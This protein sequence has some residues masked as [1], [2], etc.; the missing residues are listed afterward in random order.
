MPQTLDELLRAAK[1]TLSDADAL[2]KQR[3]SEI[4]APE[5]VQTP[6]LW[7]RV[8]QLGHA[9]PL[10]EDYSG[11]KARG[12]RDVASNDHKA[13]TGQPLSFMDKAR[14][15]IDSLGSDVA[16]VAKEQFT[17]P[18]GIAS[19]PFKAES[20]P[21][22][23]AQGV[24][25][26][27]FAGEGAEKAFGKDSSVAERGS[28][29]L[30]MLM[31][32]V[33]LHSASVRPH[34]RPVVQEHVSR[35]MMERDRFNADPVEP[36]PPG[37]TR[38]PVDLFD[39]PSYQEAA[40]PVVSPE[41]PPSATPAPAPVAP[42]S[43]KPRLAAQD[44]ADMLAGRSKFAEKNPGIEPPPG[45][46]D[47]LDRSGV[48]YNRTQRELKRLLG[49]PD[50]D[51]AEVMRMQQGAREL[52]SRLRNT[53]QDAA[54][55]PLPPLPEGFDALNSELGDLNEPAPSAHGDSELAKL[56]HASIAQQEA[57]KAANMAAANAPVP[58]GREGH[59]KLP[60]PS[61][62][63]QKY[64]TRKLDQQ[65]EYFGRAPLN[66]VA[67]TTPT[68]REHTGGGEL[69][70]DPREPPRYWAGDEKGEVTSGLLKFLARPAAGAAIGGIFGD[71]DHKM[72]DAAIGAGLGLGSHYVDPER[73][74]YFAML[75]GAAQAKNIVG[76]IGVVGH[77][78]L[79]RGMTHGIG[80]GANVLKEFL[81]PET[82]RDYVD[83]VKGERKPSMS[84]MDRPESTNTEGWTGLPF[85][86]MGAADDA[87]Q[88]A[89]RR[90]GVT[91]AADRTFQGDPKS[92]LG[93]A[94]LGYQREGGFWARFLSPFMKTQVNQNEATILPF[95]H[96]ND[97][98]AAARKEAMAKVALLGAS[99]AA[100]AAVG[101]TDFGTNHPRLAALAS[102]LTGP[103][104]MPYL[105]GQAAMRAKG[106]H[107]L[108][109]VN[110]MAHVAAQGIP[111]PSD[112]ALLPGQIVKS[113][114]PAGLDL[115]NPDDTPRDTTGGIFNPLLSRLPGLS[116]LLR[117]KGGA[118]KHHH[119]LTHE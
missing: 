7:D 50:T 87:T 44:V 41:L 5:P 1:A 93:K 78:A 15:Y 73:L 9:S 68:I 25:S 88:N 114:A 4:V 84:R 59:F 103:G 116:K 85:R 65:D 108:D 102:L 45:M 81:S 82:V 12:V 113:L 42:A 61:P 112:W 97:A 101:S 21:L 19:L 52:G 80:T 100:G 67:P 29:L 31:G 74:R 17:T 71:D 110:A 79:E 118:T 26:A 92:K 24:G 98:S 38:H 32:G 2:E 94:A 89:L 27:L 30:N 6:G 119:R 58:P 11:M 46:R 62:A 20:I 23:A 69:I 60:E 22:R 106:T 63:S 105:L 115:V 37:P 76:D 43:T 77:T 109:K 18:L 39:T 117:A 99:G 51:P 35:P 111:A 83:M 14:P 70:Q 40:A 33:G 3:D 49:V 36:P 95:T 54:A 75:T 34:E 56:L 90:A 104:Q 57:E 28:G 64:L 8:K 48:E 91:D 107:P 53:A 55:R 10:S 72:R 66:D 86:L 16:D 13:A 47:E 96:L